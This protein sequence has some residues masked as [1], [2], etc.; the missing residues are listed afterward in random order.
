M[1]VGSTMV[2]GAACVAA[3]AA[4]MLGA[5]AAASPASDE[6]ALRALEARYVRAFSDENVDAV[7]ANYAPGDGLFVF[8]AVPPRQYVGWEAYKRDWQ[9]LF[10]AFPGKAPT[11][12]SDLSLTVVGPVA[13]GHNIQTTQFTPPGGAAQT[14]VVRV[15]DVYRKIGGRWKIVQEHVSFPVDIATDKADLQSRP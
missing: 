8:D 15:S 1:A 14:L 13:Y 11:T 9:A 6:A 12:M 4:S 3:V 7:M 5:V 10:A 2:R